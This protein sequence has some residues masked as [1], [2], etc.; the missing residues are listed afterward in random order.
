MGGGAIAPLVPMVPTPMVDLLKDPLSTDTG[1]RL[2]R[3][4][5][6]VDGL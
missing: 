2:P 6:V 3:Q 4:L 1:I 5:S